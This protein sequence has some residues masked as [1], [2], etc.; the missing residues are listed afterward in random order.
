MYVVVLIFFAISN[1]YL[2]CNHFHCKSTTCTRQRNVFDTV[3]QQSLCIWESCSLTFKVDAIALQQNR[4]KIKPVQGQLLSIKLHIK[5]LKKVICV[6]SNGFL[7]WQS[8][9]GSR[10]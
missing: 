7:K 3:F 8:E 1:L 10:V 4:L 2:L 9:W 5:M 6:L